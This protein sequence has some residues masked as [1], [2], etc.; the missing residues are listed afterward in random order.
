[1]KITIRVS[2]Q[3]IAL[4]NFQLRRVECARVITDSVPSNNILRAAN[5]RRKGICNFS[6]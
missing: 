5:F 2:P 1:M 4:D 6:T 3:A